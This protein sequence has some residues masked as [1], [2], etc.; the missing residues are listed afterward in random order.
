MIRS[1]KVR[2][3]VLLVAALAL[4]AAGCGNDGDDGDDAA[5]ASVTQETVAESGGDSASDSLVAAA[6]EEG[7][8]TIYSSHDADKLNAFADAFE[9][10]YGIEVEA[11]RGVDTDLAPRVEQEFATGKRTADVFVT[12]AQAWPEANFSKGWFVEPV[13]PNFKDS[14]YDRES[15]LLEGNR[16]IVGASLRTF[17]WNTELVPDGLDDYSDLLDPSLSGGK[18]GVFDPAGGSAGIDYYLYLEEQYGEDFVEKLAAQEPRIY[19]GGLPTAEALVSGEIAAALLVPVLTTHIEAGAPVQHGIADPLWATPFTAMI[20]EGAP[21]PNAAQLLADFMI[22]RE[23]QEVLSVNNVAIL[24]DVST[25]VA[26]MDS[27]RE[28]D[29]AALTP[30]VLAEYYEKWQA[31]FL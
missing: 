16:F 26:S 4:F 18:I 7:A 14:E 1:R 12:G 8:V 29:L 13:G 25:A 19:T 9:A 24:P 2:Q 22:S 10:K 5:S 30:E 17:G 31:L 11:I 6:Q 23:G 21:H 15:Y 28:Q 27:V 3:A 20:L